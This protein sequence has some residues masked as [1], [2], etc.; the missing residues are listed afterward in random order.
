MK[1]DTF[2]LIHFGLCVVCWLGYIFTGMYILFGLSIMFSIWY[3]WDHFTG[4]LSKKSELKPL[5]E[6]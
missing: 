4:K 6:Q 1:K 3:L 5:S 2:T